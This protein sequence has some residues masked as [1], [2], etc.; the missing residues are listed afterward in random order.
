[1]RAE[2]AARRD[3]GA[4]AEPSAETMAEAIAA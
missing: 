3:K 4:T 1:M 2:H